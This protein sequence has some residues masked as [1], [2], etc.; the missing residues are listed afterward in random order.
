VITDAKIEPHGLT[1]APGTYWQLER[2][3]FFFTDPVSSKAGAPVFNR[4]VGLKDSWTKK[5]EAPARPVKQQQAK[6]AANAAETVKVFEAAPTPA[7][8]A[9]REKLKASGTMSE[10]EA[11]LLTRNDVVHAF[12]DK[13]AGSDT[14]LFKP[15]AKWIVNQL[16]PLA[17]DDLSALKLT[18]EQ[19]RELIAL[20]ETKAIS[21]GAARQVLGVMFDKGG[22]PKAIVAQLGL[23]QVSDAGAIEKIVK[24]VLDKHPEQTAKLKAGEAKMAGF[25]VGQVMKESKGQANPQLVQAAI[26]KL[27]K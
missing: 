5:E 27:L 6:P 10:E 11:V 18:P 23:Q 12:F 1:A 24:A 9:A 3:G 14:Q 26:D 7:L 21:Q 17:K 15:A 20:G 2:Q 22:D 16:L 8:Q 25:L 19:F 4:A 13:V